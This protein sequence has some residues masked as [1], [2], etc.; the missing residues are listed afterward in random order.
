VPLPVSA[1]VASALCG[2]ASGGCRDAMKPAVEPVS[3]LL[4][5]G[6]DAAL[7]KDKAEYLS[8]LAALLFQATTSV[9]DWSENLVKAVEKH[10]AAVD[11]WWQ[12]RILRQAAR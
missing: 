7:F 8:L 4:Q 11:P 3:T 9:V 6:G 5:T 2:M 1:V 10:V 12:Y